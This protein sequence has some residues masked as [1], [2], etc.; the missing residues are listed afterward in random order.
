VS[1]VEEI[2]EQQPAA[3]GDGRVALV[4]GAGSGIGRATAARLLAAGWSVIG[5]DL[6][7]S[8]L[9]WLGDHGIIA[10]GVHA[11][12]AVEA[13]NE[14]AVGVALERFGQLDA[15][16]LNA[17]V[18]HMGAFHAIDAG[19]YDHVLGV[20]VRGVGLGLR[21]ALP[22]LE[23]S[24]HPSV[25]AVAS[26]SGT[27]GEPFMSLYAASKAAV[28]NLMSSAA[29]ELGPRG[30][31]INCVCPGPTLTA[32]TRPA[33]EANPAVEAAVRRQV[34]LKRFGRPEEIAEVIAFLASPASSFVHGAAIPV[35]GGVSAGSGQA[36]PPDA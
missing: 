17:G 19:A 35:D 25:I 27:G 31:R 24:D 2:L 4:T 12:A 16:V 1:A 21:A 11:D 15:L 3:V 33:V 23:R 32:M 36:L 26:V 29:V 22:A 18:A 13:D 7:E 10:A 34:P 20:N 8:R 9:A 6:D 5:T 30:I 14:R 28:I